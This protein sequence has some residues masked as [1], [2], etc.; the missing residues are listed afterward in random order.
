MGLGSIIKKMLKVGGRN[1]VLFYIFIGISILAGAGSWLAS[2]KLWLLPV[3]FAGSFV[4]LFLLFA[5][6]ILVMG[7]AVDMKK[8]QE[9]DNGF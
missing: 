8:P 1:L 5:L 3:A 7:T 6:T 9:K 4:G 2:G